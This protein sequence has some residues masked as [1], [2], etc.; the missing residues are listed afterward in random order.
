MSI[1][2]DRTPWNA[3]PGA[4][5]SDLPDEREEDE[6]ECMICGRGMPL[7]RMGEEWICEDCDA[8]DR[9][10]EENEF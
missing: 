3:E 6:P 8:G 2:Y 7:I 1:D 5:Y 9:I 4:L 10:P